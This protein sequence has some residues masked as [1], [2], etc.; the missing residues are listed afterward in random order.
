MARL[1]CAAG[2][3]ASRRRDFYFYGQWPVGPTVTAGRAKKQGRIIRIELKMRFV[4]KTCSIT[5]LNGERHVVPQTRCSFCA[6]HSFEG[7][8]IQQRNSRYIPYRNKVKFCR[9]DAGYFSLCFI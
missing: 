4:V 1:F 3:R 7:L 5:E 8:V 6:A 2:E 9:R